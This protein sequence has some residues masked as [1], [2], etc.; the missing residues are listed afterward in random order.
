MNVIVKSVFILVIL[1]PEALLLFFFA[2][3]YLI[4][5]FSRKNN[6]Q[7]CIVDGN[8]F[9]TAMWIK[10]G[11]INLYP[12]TIKVFLLALGF[13]ISLIALIMLMKNYNE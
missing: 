4:E 13:T 2:N 11:D 5:F 10:F 12:S 9:P 3:A 8:P 1:F 7:I 6:P